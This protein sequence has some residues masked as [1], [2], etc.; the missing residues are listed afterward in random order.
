M[1]GLNGEYVLRRDKRP[2]PAEPAI[3][4]KWFPKCEQPL[5]VQ[6]KALGMILTWAKREF[7][8]EVTMQATPVQFG[9]Q[10]LQRS[11]PDGWEYP[12]IPDGFSRLLHAISFP[13]RME[14][15][16]DPAGAVQYDG[17]VMF[18]GTATQMPIHVPGLYDIQHDEVATFEPYR[19]G[20]YRVDVQV[21]QDWRHI[22]LVP[23]LTSER[24][25]EVY[26][27]RRMT[28]WPRRPGME[29]GAWLHVSEMHLLLE[30]GIQPWPY[31]IKKRLLFAP[32]SPGTRPL[33]FWREKLKEAIEKLE[34]RIALAEQYSS[35]TPEDIRD[36]TTLRLCRAGLRSI[37]LQTIGRLHH[38]GLGKPHMERNEEGELELVEYDPLTPFTARWHQPAWTAAIWARARVQATLLALKAPMEAIQEIRGDA[39]FFDPALAPE[40]QD[41]GKVGSFRR[42]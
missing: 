29:F 17:R 18:L 19:Q 12:A 42:K 8:D 40:I 3:S 9:C 21:P 1:N 15:F 41:D 36:N 20:W 30:N 24:T 5:E 23:V 22:G 13:H 26:G 31:T 27:I 16:A 28:L 6:L 37:A 39:V 32:E 7:G 33:R 25:A 11:L 4:E 38:N 10:L 2:I 34:R 35:G 14:K